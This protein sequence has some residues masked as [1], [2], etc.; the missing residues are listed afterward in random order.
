MT[1]RDYIR[2]AKIVRQHYELQEDCAMW[3][4]QSFIRFFREDNIRFDAD[5]FRE[6]CKV[7]E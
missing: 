4:E 1:K 2:A 6:A 7:E 5:H 3:V